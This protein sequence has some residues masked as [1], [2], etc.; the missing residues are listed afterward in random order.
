MIEF[1]KFKIDETGLSAIVIIVA[2]LIM[3]V[4]AGL[5]MLIKGGCF[6]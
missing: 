1:G 3:V 2:L 6:L 5:D 4:L